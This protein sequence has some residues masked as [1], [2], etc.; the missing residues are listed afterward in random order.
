M[1]PPEGRAEP[2]VIITVPL[3]LA[4]PTTGHMRC[5]GIVSICLSQGL[6]RRGLLQQGGSGKMDRR[7]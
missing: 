3:R 7:D 2:P 5:L 4:L 6:Q 1:P